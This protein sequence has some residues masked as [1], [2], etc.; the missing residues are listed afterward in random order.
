MGVGLWL[1]LCLSFGIGW[2]FD[3]SR[4]FGMMTCGLD[5]PEVEMNLLICSFGMDLG[6]DRAS[7]RLGYLVGI[8]LVGKSCLFS[9]IP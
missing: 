9:F 2:L 6:V 8:V 1:S 4:A 5:I 7:C 3:H